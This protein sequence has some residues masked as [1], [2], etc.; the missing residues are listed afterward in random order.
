MGPRSKDSSPFRAP[1]YLEDCREDQEDSSSSFITVRSSPVF[2]VPRKTLLTPHSWATQRGL[3]V[4][5]KS[6]N[7]SRLEQNLHVTDFDLEKEDLDSITKLDRNLRF[8][9]PT[10]VSLYFSPEL[11]FSTS[12]APPLL[13][14]EP[15]VSRNITHFRISMIKID[16]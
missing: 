5:P 10:D 3:A 8:N 14:T 12:L 4:I 7:Q 11:I 1:S 2:P 15:L 9:N 13:T 6:N 16:D